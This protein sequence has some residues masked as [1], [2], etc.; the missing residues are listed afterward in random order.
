MPCLLCAKKEKGADENRPYL[1]SYCTMFAGMYT[2]DSIQKKIQKY[3]E[4]KRKEEADFLERCFT[5]HFKPK[6]KS[7]EELHRRKANER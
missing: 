2:Y 1:C 6:Q 3:R 7:T 4:A 5:Q